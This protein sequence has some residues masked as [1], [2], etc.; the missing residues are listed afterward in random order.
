MTFAPLAR[1]IPGL[2]NRNDTPG[3]VSDFAHT[4]LRLP[5]AYCFCIV[6]SLFI[7]SQATAIIVSSVETLW[8]ATLLLGFAYGSL[9]GS[10]PAVVIEW[11]GLG[12]STFSVVRTNSID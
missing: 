4:R 11:F 7:V 2:T 5:R 8:I 6:S 3:L 9:F 10:C 1:P 12:K